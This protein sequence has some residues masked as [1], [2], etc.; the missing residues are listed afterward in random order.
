[1]RNQGQKSWEIPPKSPGTGW[2]PWR[3]VLRARRRAAKAA[4]PHRQ[5]KPEGVEENERGIV[6][7]PKL[8]IGWPPAAHREVVAE[9]EDR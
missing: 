6:R 8:A 4:A 2:T 9:A 3:P 5:Q 7:F 1:M